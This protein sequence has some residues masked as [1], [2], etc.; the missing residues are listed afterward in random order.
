[1]VLLYIILL[2]LHS[3]PMKCGLILILWVLLN[4]FLYSLD[5]N[6]IFPLALIIYLNYT[7]FSSLLLSTKSLFSYTFHL[8]LSMSIFSY[9]IHFIH[10][11]G[12]V[13]FSF[14]KLY[15]KRKSPFLLGLILSHIMIIITI[16][17]YIFHFVCRTVSDRTS[18]FF[19]E[20]KQK[21]KPLKSILSRFI[22]QLI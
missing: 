11:G 15:K 6:L 20:I 18:L 12:K 17:A 22:F 14:T 1:M 13:P 7:L 4:Y 19:L 2:F 8:F 5:V 3:K 9:N 10:Y 21:V 16:I